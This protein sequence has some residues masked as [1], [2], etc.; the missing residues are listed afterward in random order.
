MRLLLLA[1]WIAFTLGLKISPGLSEELLGLLSTVNELDKLLIESS[2][3]SNTGSDPFPF[4]ID[5]SLQKICRQNS[6]LFCHHACVPGSVQISPWL[7]YAMAT[8]RYLQY[9]TPINYVQ[10]IGTHNSAITYA[11]AYGSYDNALTLLFTWLMKSPVK[12]R[13]ADQQ[14][15]LTD[16]LNMGIRQIELDTH[17]LYK[18]HQLKICHAGTSWPALDELI[19]EINRVL[20][21]DIEWDS[22]S[23]GCWSRYHR[24]FEDAVAEV[25]SSAL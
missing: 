20:D 22:G 23:L 1:G 14:I 18:D 3:L 16:Q 7:R 19:A 11:N 17:W 6:T 12:W 24:E 13:T 21:W 10:M 8:Q 5:C 25:S 2:I 9:A 4:P 15:S